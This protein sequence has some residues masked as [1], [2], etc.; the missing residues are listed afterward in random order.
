MFKRTRTQQNISV[1]NNL[2]TQLEYCFV[3]YFMSRVDCRI[4]FQKL[5]QYSTR[6]MNFQSPFCSQLM[7][8]QDSFLL[9]PTDRRSM[10]SRGDRHM[11]TIRNIQSSDF[12]NYRYDFNFHSDWNTRASMILDS[13]RIDEKKVSKNFSF[14]TFRFYRFDVAIMQ[15]KDHSIKLMDAIVSKHSQLCGRQCIR[16][17]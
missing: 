6:L 9:D 5:F 10:D 2:W 3:V 8:Y 4:L 14:D 7:W 12:G 11:L 15:W 1:K 17:S 13:E 16:T